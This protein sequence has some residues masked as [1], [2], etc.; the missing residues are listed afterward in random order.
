MRLTIAHDDAFVGDADIVTENCCISM[1]RRT[2]IVT[3]TERS[4][5]RL[6]SVFIKIEHSWE[7]MGVNHC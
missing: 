6:P 2:T 7:D 5:K 1:K 4:Y 3:R